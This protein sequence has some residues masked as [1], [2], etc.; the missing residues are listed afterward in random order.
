M[1]T[2]STTSTKVFDLPR[3][4]LLPPEIFEKRQLQ[5]AQAGLGLVVLVAVV[6]VGLVYVNGGSSVTNAKARLDAA[7]TT[8]TQLQ[9]KV[10]QLSYVT[11]EAGQAQA[12]QGMLTQATGSAIP[13]STYLA[14]LSLLTPKNVW[15]TSITMTSNV[16]PG[17][18]APGATPPATVGTVTFSG[19][20][21][22]HN[23]VATWLDSA[24][25]ENGFADPYFNSSTESLVPGTG[26]VSG[27]PTKT[28]VTFGSSVNLTSA[29]LC[30]AQPGKC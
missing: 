30:S 4:N 13:F 23:D 28:W 16:T 21:L 2:T 22:A 12:A 26:G 5:R 17:S 15:F 8:Q 25:K 9:S 24:A 27:V 3:V 20:A 19:Q 14:D 10:N 1:S 6:G 29:A 11:A 18:L 7:Q